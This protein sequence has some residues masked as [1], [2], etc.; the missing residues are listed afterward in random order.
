M[1][2]LYIINDEHLC[3]FDEVSARHG[4][5]SEVPGINSAVVTTQRSPPYPHPYGSASPL[6]SSF[7]HSFLQIFIR[8]KP[9]ELA[10]NILQVLEIKEP[11]LFEPF[12]V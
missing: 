1:R 9:D 3:R 12:V 6:C 8:S 7:I 11:K 10:K 5:Y 4:R 2:S